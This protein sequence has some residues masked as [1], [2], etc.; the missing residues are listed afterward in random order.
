MVVFVSTT[1]TTTTTTHPRHL[2]PFHPFHSPTSLN[3]FSTRLGL[4]GPIIPIC[5]LQGIVQLCS[6]GIVLYESTIHHPT[7]RNGIFMLCFVAYDLER[8]GRSAW[9]GVHPK[10]R[11][12]QFGIQENWVS[13]TSLSAKRAGLGM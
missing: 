7:L 6:T 4:S 5:F 3:H 9:G 12:A 11:A 13:R 2:S 8:M 10:S 1:T